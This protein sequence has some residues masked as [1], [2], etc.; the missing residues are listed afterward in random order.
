MNGFVKNDLINSLIV[1]DCEGFKLT[2]FTDKETVS[3]LKNTTLIIE[4]HDFVDLFISEKI[5]NCFSE[6]H[7]I[8]SIF[9]IDDFKKVKMYN[10]PEL[11]PADVTTKFSI[12]NEGRPYNMEWLILTPKN[13]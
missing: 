8:K 9:S 1:S 3:H 6:S 11:S 12:L 10:Y 2:L 13:L 5:K 4:T 7:F